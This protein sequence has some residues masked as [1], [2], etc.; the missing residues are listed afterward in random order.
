MR[1]PLAAAAALAVLLALLAPW[2]L[3][4]AQKEVCPPA[5]EATEPR[6]QSLAV[7]P[8]ELP[9][10]VGPAPLHCPICGV[11]L[12]AG[13]VV[14]GAE[15]RLTEAVYQ[16]LGHNRCYELLPPG[17]AEGA[18]QRLLQQTMTGTAVSYLRGVGNQL[19]AAFVLGGI[20]Y[21]YRER[22]GT[23]YS[24]SQAASIGF[25]LHVVRTA[26]GAIVWSGRFDE[27]QKAL[28]ENIFNIF[29]FFRRGVR[30]LTVDEFAAQ[31]V[32]ETLKDFPE[33]LPVAK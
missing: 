11:S 9:R 4:A 30:W 6:G 18:Y 8:L 26:D 20:L 23:T 15:A 21:R 14:P 31:A 19:G 29:Q 16:W 10:E 27:T 33:Q 13:E 5:A 24:A 1:G 28:T 12:S 22:V 17:A 32:A 3:L 2:P 25:D 7:M